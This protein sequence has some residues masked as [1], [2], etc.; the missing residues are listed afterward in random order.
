MG[1]KIIFAPQALEK[2]EQIEF[3]KPQHMTNWSYFAKCGHDFSHVAFQ[4]ADA[5]AHLP[6]RLLDMRASVYPD[7]AVAS[8]K[9]L[10][11]DLP[12]ASIHRD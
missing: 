5:L 9:A 7:V 6:R 3:S 1:W 12:H 10:M 4:A 11:V 8:A 2:L